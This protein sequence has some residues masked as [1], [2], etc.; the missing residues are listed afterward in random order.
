M[1]QAG[2]L[3]PPS[4][5]SSAERARWTIFRPRTTRRAWRWVL[6]RRCAAQSTRG[7]WSW[8]KTLLLGGQGQLPF[9]F[10]G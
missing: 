3:G 2:N 8:P 9:N 10:C 5:L 1:L 7:R 4:P 6:T